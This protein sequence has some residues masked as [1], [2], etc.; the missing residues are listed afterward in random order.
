[1]KVRTSVL[2]GFAL[3]ALSSLTFAAC[4]ESTTPPAP[5]APTISVAPSTVTLQVGQTATL[6]AAVSGAANQNVT[7][8]SGNP[9]VA[10]VSAAGVVTARAAG[11]TGIIAIAQADTT[12]RAAAS[13]TVTAAPVVPV[14]LQLVPDQAQVQVGNTVQLVGIVGGPANV[15]QVVNY[16]SSAPAVATVT[17]TGGLVTGV[18]PGTAVITARAGADANVIRT[19]TIT[20]TAGPPATPIQIS[21]TP[22][23]VTTTV[24]GTQ[25]FVANI[26]GSTNTQ[27]MW[28]SETPALA[29]INAQGLATALAPGTAIITAMAAADTT[30]RVQATL[31]IGAQAP[32]PSI[33]IQEVSVDGVTG[34]RDAE[35][36]YSGRVHVRVN[37]T[38]DVSHNVRRVEVR[39]DGQTVC[40][41]TFSQPLGTTQGVATISCDIN[42]AELTEAGLPRFPNAARVISAVAMNQDNEVVAEA[43]VP[44]ITL[45]NVDRVDIV[46]FTTVPRSSTGP[47]VSPVDGLLWH[48]GD[49]RVTVRPIMYGGGTA[50]DL[51]VCIN[52]MNVP[53]VTEGGVATDRA[54]NT[55]SCRFVAAPSAGA[56]F[57]TTFP[58]SA[59][60]GN[61]S[62]QR[63]VA[64][65]STDD[66]RV[67]VVGTVTTAGG[68]GPTL[69]TG[70]S[71]QRFMRLDNLR[72]VALLT[73]VFPTTQI[74][75]GRI[76]VGA[77]FSFAATTSTT[78]ATGSVVRGAYDPLPGSGIQTASVTFFAAPT[79]VAGGA[80]TAGQTTA[81]QDTLVAFIGRAQQVTSGSQL[82]PSITLEY[83]LV[84]RLVDVMGNVRYYYVGRFGADPTAP[85]MVEDGA[86]RPQDFAFGGTAGTEGSYFFNIEDDLAGP[87]DLIWRGIRWTNDPNTG[88]DIGRCLT[89][90]VATGGADANGSPSRTLAQCNF[91]LAPIALVPLTAGGLVAQAEFVIG[92]DEGF[93]QY[94]FRGRDRASNQTPSFFRN[95][96]I[97]RTNPT[98]TMTG[99]S[100][101]LAQNSVT[102]TGVMR[103]NLDLNY[104]E[105]RAEI[106]GFTAATGLPDETLAFSGAISISTFGLPLV[107]SFSGSGTA[108]IIR[109]VQLGVSG[110]LLQTTRVG[111]RVYDHAMNWAFDGLASPSAAPSAISANVTAFELTTTQ[112]TIDSITPAQLRAVATVGAADPVPF[113]RVFFYYQD[114][115]TGGNILIGIDQ[116]ATV[117][118]GLTQRTFRWDIMLTV[119]QLDAPTGTTVFAVAVDAQGNALMSNGI[120][121]ST[122]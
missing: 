97:D 121:L 93:Y 36:R 98:V 35:G 96:L 87:R 94:E 38:A 53:A 118:T 101:S 17:P 43:T 99:M 11:T 65:L 51:T 42:T 103:D 82:E 79:T 58:K 23:D 57:T 120:T 8:R 95:A 68:E 77:G 18:T 56:V 80:P 110:A 24:G 60:V 9:A 86:S 2:R 115:V 105:L 6:S 30:R 92:S 40:F 34:M 13:V 73:P 75:D 83:D 47:R 84:T 46:E 29:T 62:T 100:F 107:E 119:D 64:N 112:T 5:P 25:Q 78:T 54:A 41:Q 27:V 90:L 26:T 19:S 106:P 45:L 102:V 63:G 14:T 69:T 21:I 22:T 4:D 85:V 12:V 48:E 1:M 49:V 39:L 88:A 70:Q 91:A 31:R 59:A 122:Q 89:T 44:A 61:A 10:E 72:P 67:S 74:V 66:L 114:P 104:Y 109:G 113:T 20:V 117:Q 7:W 55:Q 3:L 108:P 76:W 111:F 33:S 52:A 71:A 32:P 28:R 116:Q 50:A 15:S 81:G 16:T 37:V